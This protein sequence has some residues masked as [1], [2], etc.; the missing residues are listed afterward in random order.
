[1]FKE[2]QIK[3]VKNYSNRQ[4]KQK[5]PANEKIRLAKLNELKAKKQHQKACDMKYPCSAFP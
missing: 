4:D 3:I 1:M 2:V 5:V